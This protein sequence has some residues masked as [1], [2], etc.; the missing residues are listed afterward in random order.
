MHIIKFW[1]VRRKFFHERDFF[2]LSR[3]YEKIIQIKF[4]MFLNNHMIFENEKFFLIS[5]SFLN[6]FNNKVSMK[7]KVEKMMMKEW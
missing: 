1:M 4:G 5:Y 3:P 2:N 6:F 7:I